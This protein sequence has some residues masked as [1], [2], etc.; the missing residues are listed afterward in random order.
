MEDRFHTLAGQFNII[1][2]R[3]IAAY[4]RYPD[5]FQFRVRAAGEAPDT[6]SL[7]H[8]RSDDGFPEKSASACNQ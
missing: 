1:R 7:C 8:K 2:I 5:L 3:K 4:M 6:L